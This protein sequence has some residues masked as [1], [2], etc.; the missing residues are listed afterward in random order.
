MHVQCPLC[1]SLIFLSIYH[2]FFSPSLSLPPPLSLSLSPSLPLFQLS[3]TSYSFE[4]VTYH[5]LYQRLPKFSYQTLTE[6]YD[7]RNRLYRLVSLLGVSFD[8]T[9]S[10]PGP[11][12]LTI[13]WCVVMATVFFWR[14]SI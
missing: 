5:T 12:S 3:L 7:Y 14:S 10:L 13:T 8:H 1:S 11:E 2:I 6:W 9:H 4:S